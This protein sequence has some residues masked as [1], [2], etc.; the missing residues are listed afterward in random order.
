[1]GGCDT[2]HVRTLKNVATEM[3]LHMLAYIM[4]CGMAM[5]GIP[6]MITAMKTLG[7]LGFQQTRF[8]VIAERRCREALPNTLKMQSF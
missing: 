2:F 8:S 4:A 1:M 5:M 7:R 3:A 6:A